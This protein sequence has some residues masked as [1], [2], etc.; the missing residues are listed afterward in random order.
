GQA[1]GLEALRLPSTSPAN[2]RLSLTEKLEPW[3]NA[4]VRAGLPRD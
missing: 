3:R 2:A 1:Q 4:F